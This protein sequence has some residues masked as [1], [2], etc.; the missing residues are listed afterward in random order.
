M[1]EVIFSNQVLQ[2]LEDLA[3][4][5]FHEEYFGYVESAF[6]Y[7]DKLIDYVEV[8]INTFPHKKTPVK[9]LHLGSHYIFYTSN[10]RTTWYLFFE[11]RNFNYLITGILNNHCA[12]ASF[13]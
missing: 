12:E 8:N 5:L 4:V 2:E 7:V 10:P 11:L 13:I 9:L 3:L 6:S 1:G